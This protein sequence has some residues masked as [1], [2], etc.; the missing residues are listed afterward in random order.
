[1]S[2]S[3]I[4]RQVLYVPAN[5]QRQAGAQDV[6]QS[7]ARLRLIL[8]DVFKTGG[9]LD[10]L[11][12]GNDD[13]EDHDSLN[14][15]QYVQGVEIEQM[16]ASRT[17][18]AV[19]VACEVGYLRHFPNQAEASDTRMTLL[20]SAAREIALLSSVYLDLPSVPAVTFDPIRIPKPENTLYVGVLQA[21]NR[22]F[23]MIQ[24][25]KTSSDYNDVTQPLLL[26][27]VDPYP[28]YWNDSWD[29]PATRRPLYQGDI[30]VS[31]DDTAAPTQSSAQTFIFA[32]SLSPEYRDM[33]RS[34][35]GNE[36]V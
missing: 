22:Q 4:D 6:Y 16:L 20:L 33:V 15:S 30:L 24:P 7:S 2:T 14:T 21:F 28:A 32:Q 1:M 34:Q 8:R 12:L 18:D 27:K 36:Q 13:I 35:Y 31:L 10:E 26:W 23:G 5:E 29:L 9:V 11:N 25:L 3:E 19:H 17:D